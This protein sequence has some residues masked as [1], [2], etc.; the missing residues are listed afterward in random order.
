MTSYEHFILSSLLF[1]L[2]PKETE[3][4]LACL[5]KVLELE[6]LKHKPI[7]ELSGGDI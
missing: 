1:R 5:L 3:V 7:R 4:R 2:S 6:D